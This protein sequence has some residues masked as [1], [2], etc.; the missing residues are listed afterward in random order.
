MMYVLDLRNSKDLQKDNFPTFIHDWSLALNGIPHQQ[1]PV[2]GNG[3]FCAAMSEPEAKVLMA[4]NTQ[5]HI[6][7]FSPH[8]V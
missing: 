4:G 1:W 8:T 5:T 6:E 7:K 3:R 2:T